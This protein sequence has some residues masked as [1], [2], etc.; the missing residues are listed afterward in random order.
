[1]EILK[2]IIC[3]DLSKEDWRRLAGR[4]DSTFFESEKTFQVDRLNG[5]YYLTTNACD[6]ASLIK[7]YCQVNKQGIEKIE[8]LGEDTDGWQEVHANTY[9]NVENFLK[10]IW[11]EN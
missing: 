1:M 4:I 10:E 3:S 9:N 5:Y 8:R 7:V 11:D 6:D 2:Q